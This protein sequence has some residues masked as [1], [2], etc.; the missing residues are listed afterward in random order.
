VDISS[1]V[2][3]VRRS[4]EDLIEK[5]TDGTV[6]ILVIGCGKA[7]L[8]ALYCLSD[9]K[10]TARSKHPKLEFQILAVDNRRDYVDQVMKNNLADAAAVVDAK[11]AREL[12]DFT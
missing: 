5:K 4:L 11:N 2:P 3:Q 10:L 6:R 7:G 12:H 8:T 9:I 1:L